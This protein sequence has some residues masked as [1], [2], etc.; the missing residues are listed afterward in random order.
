MQFTS[1]EVDCIQIFQT[2][3]VL[4]IFFLFS[5]GSANRAPVGNTTTNVKSAPTGT[6]PTSS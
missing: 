5:L 1:I 6:T 3:F 2:S 4:N